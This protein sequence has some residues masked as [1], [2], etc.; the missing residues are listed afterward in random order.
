[1][2]HF[3]LVVQSTCNYLFGIYKFHE[4]MGHVFSSLCSQSLVQTPDP[5]KA[6]MSICGINA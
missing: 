6:L 4:G 3:F 5:E 2:L 1:M